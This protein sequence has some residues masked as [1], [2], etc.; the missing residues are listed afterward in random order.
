MAGDRAQAGSE[1]GL[2]QSGQGAQPQRKRKP[3]GNPETGTD[4][5]NKAPRVFQDAP[6]PWPALREQKN[7]LFEKLSLRAYTYASSDVAFKKKLKL[8]L[9][10]DHE[11][12]LLFAQYIKILSQFE[13]PADITLPVIE[14]QFF[15]LVISDFLAE[16][17]HAFEALAIIL[18]TNMDPNFSVSSLNTKVRLAAWHLTKT[19]GRTSKEDAFLLAYFEGRLSPTKFAW[20]NNY[21][22]TWLENPAAYIARFPHYE[23]LRTFVNLEW[24]FSGVADKAIKVLHTRKVPQIEREKCKQAV[25]MYQTLFNWDE[26]EDAKE[27]KAISRVG[28]IPK[29]VATTYE[30]HDGR[31]YDVSDEDFTLTCRYLDIP[32]CGADYL[33]AAVEDIEALASRMSKAKEKYRLP[34]TISKTKFSSAGMELVAASIHLFPEPAYTVDVECVK[35]GGPELFP[36]AA[37]FIPTIDRLASARFRIKNS[38]DLV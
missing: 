29:E 12:L 18:Y 21:I 3:E 1:A 17:S 6:T 30:V 27:I 4:N 8:R 11:M 22:E 31:M 5:A 23:H 16:K 35:P 10:N 34:K 33:A 37:K 25:A 20:R 32:G 14:K 19:E 9:C 28:G 2:E 15:P 26:D 24:Q 38:V 7:A 36:A 13:L